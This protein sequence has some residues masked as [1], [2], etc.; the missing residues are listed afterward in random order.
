[1]LEKPRRLFHIP[2]ETIN[3]AVIEAG[4]SLTRDEHTLVKFFSQFLVQGEA[5]ANWAWGRDSA[6]WRRGAAG[7]A[8]MAAWT[9]AGFKLPE[10]QVPVRIGPAALVLTSHRLFWAASST[11]MQGLSMTLEFH[12]PMS[13]DLAAVRATGSTLRRTWEMLPIFKVYK[14][15]IA[16]SPPLH[17]GFAK[18]KGFPDNLRHVEAIAGAVNA[19]VV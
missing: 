12:D 9:A 4:F 14:L 10:R 3:M 2:A 15:V 17:M 11:S 5:V 1:M 16:T 19:K 18:Y 8:E 13:F 6:E 7:A